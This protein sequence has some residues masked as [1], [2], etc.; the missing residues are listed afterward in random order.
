MNV[1]VGS[2]DSVLWVWVFF[3]PNYGCLVYAMECF[4]I[5]FAIWMIFVCVCVC[6]NWPCVCVFHLFL[7]KL[8]DA[9]RCILLLICCLGCFVDDEP[10]NMNI[11][12]SLCQIFCIVFCVYVH[13]NCTLYQGK[14]HW[15][16]YATEQKS[17]HGQRCGHMGQIEAVLH[18]NANLILILMQL[19]WQCCICVGCKSSQRKFIVFAYL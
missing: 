9:C 14:L 10:K 17:G 16:N 4:L 3:R 13:H 11:R 12:F 8:A 6:V 7:C 1:L 15:K 5:A 19:R 2:T 18:K